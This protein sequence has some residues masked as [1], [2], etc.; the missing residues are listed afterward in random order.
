MQYMMQYTGVTIGH[1]D[2]GVPDPA[3]P[4]AS[5]NVHEHVQWVS[6]DLYVIL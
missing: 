5:T 4:S 3:R 6:D 2:Q 1:M